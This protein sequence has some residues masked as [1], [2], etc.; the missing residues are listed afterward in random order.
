M[1]DVLTGLLTGLLIFLAI[2]LAILYLLSPFVLYGIYTRLGETNT[3][4]RDLL[5]HTRPPLAK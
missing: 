3:L 2:L 5:G 4:L 1:T